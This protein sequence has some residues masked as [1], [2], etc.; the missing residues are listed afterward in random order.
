MEKTIQ[1]NTAEFLEALNSHTGETDRFA[2]FGMD[3]KGRE[4]ALKIIAAMHGKPLP[5]TTAEWTR[6]K[7]ALSA[8]GV[9]I[10]GPY[11]EDI[12]TLAFK[13]TPKLRNMKAV[14]AYQPRT[15]GG[16][17]AFI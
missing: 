14:T 9:S 17:F 12:V 16:A 11:D 5:R 8:L 7:R 2:G 1:V 10:G 3:F 13:S 4:G 6:M 15:V